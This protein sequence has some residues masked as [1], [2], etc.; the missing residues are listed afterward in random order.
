LD[1]DFVLMYSKMEKHRVNFDVMLNLTCTNKEI[2]EQ[3][4]PSTHSD[5]SYALVVLLECLKGI[6]ER[7][8]LFETWADIL[9]NE[10][11]FL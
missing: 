6:Q 1:E 10:G 5:A 3:L 7:R 2:I 8:K 11:T 9:E 4:L